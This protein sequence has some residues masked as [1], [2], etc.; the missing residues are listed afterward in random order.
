MITD[1]FERERH[2]TQ[3]VGLV[4]QGLVQVVEDAVVVEDQA[5][6]LQLVV[7]PVHACDGLQQRGFHLAVQ[8]QGLQDGRVEAGGEHVAHHQDLHLAQR[9]VA[10]LVGL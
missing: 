4:V 7:R 3:L 1:G 10:V 8:V 9:L 2:V 5:V 6:A